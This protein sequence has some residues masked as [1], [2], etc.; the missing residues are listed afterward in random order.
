MSFYV[1]LILSK[2]NRITQTGG[3]DMPE[4]IKR[5]GTDSAKW[6]GLKQTFGEEGLLPFW[7]ADMEFRVD[8]DI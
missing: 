7:V 2:A 4:Y 8:S 1:K 5:S 6:D 3:P